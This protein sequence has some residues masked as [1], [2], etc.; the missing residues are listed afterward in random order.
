MMSTIVESSVK[1]DLEDKRVL[2][3]LPWIRDPVQPL[4]D[5]H[6]DN[7]NLHQVLRVYKTQCT[8]GQEVLETV[9]IAH[10]ELVECKFMTKLS[11]LLE[12]LSN[13]L[14]KK[15][16]LTV[17]DISTESDWQSGLPWMRLETEY[18]PLS[19]LITNYH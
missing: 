4:I 11:N 3:K 1:L 19:P 13:L 6:R 10:S 17:E 14:T 2:V 9:R 18:M 12:K 7:L 15:Q 5:E 8:K 16:D